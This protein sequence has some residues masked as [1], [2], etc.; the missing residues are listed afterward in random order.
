MSLTAGRLCEAGVDPKLVLKRVSISVDLP[1]PVSPAGHH[2][3]SYLI[4]FALLL[5]R[6]GGSVLFLPI[7]ILAFLVLPIPIPSLTR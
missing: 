3:L 2:C 4:H 7:P 1:M 6:D 5:T